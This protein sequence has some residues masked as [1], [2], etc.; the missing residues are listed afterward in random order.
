MEAPVLSYDGE[1]TINLENRADFTLPVVTATDNEDAEVEVTSVIT[2]ADGEELEA[3]DTTVAGTYTVTYSAVDAAGNASEKLV[4]TVVV[5][6]SPSALAVEEAVAAIDALPEV[7]NLTLEDSQDV[8]DARA[9]VTAAVELGA[10]EEDVTNLSKLVDAEA[11][12][13]TAAVKAV[14]N[15]STRASLLEALQNPV[16][17]LTGVNSDWIRD[18]QAEISKGVFIRTVAEIQ[19][20]VIDV[21]ANAKATQTLDEALADVEDAMNAEELLAALKAP[22]L[23]LT[24]IQDDLANVY[25]Y[26]YNHPGDDADVS[27]VEGLQEYVVDAAPAKLAKA[28][29]AIE[30]APTQAELLT[31]LKSDVLGLSED[32][33]DGSVKEYASLVFEMNL[34]TVADVQFVLDVTAAELSVEDTE[35]LVGSEE[36]EVFEV[37]TQEEI[38]DAEASLKET[39]KVVNN[40]RDG[41][42]KKDLL[43]RLDAV[44]EAIADAKVTLKV[45]NATDAV[46]ALLTIEDED[47]SGLV[48]DLLNDAETADFEDTL[49]AFELAYNGDGEDVKGAVDLVAALD[50]GT[51]KEVL[52]DRLEVIAEKAQLAKAQNAVFVADNASL[53]TN[54]DIV[55]AI[56]LFTK[57]ETAVNGYMDSVERDAL[58]DSLTTIKED[59]ELEAKGQVDE[60]LVV[61]KDGEDTGLVADLEAALADLEENY[62]D[63]NVAAFNTALEKASLAYAGDSDEEVLGAVDV[64]AELFSGSMKTTLDNRLMV[65]G[66]RIDMAE[67]TFAVL[68]VEKANAATPSEVVAALELFED[69]QEMVT[70]LPTSDEKSDLQDR[71]DTVKDSLDAMYAE[72]ITSVNDAEDATEI[73][74]ALKVALELEGDAEHTDLFFSVYGKTVFTSLD[75]IQAAYDDVVLT[76]DVN[77]ADVKTTDDALLALDHKAYINLGTANRVEVA[78]LFFTIHNVTAKEE[79]EFKSTEEVVAALD[80]AIAKYNSLLAGVNNAST[81]VEMESALQSMYNAYAPELKK[82]VT[83]DEAEDVLNTKNTEGFSGFKTFEQINTVLTPA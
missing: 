20:N 8:A 3:I 42:Y 13:T 32:V 61:V 21:V 62:S 77:S 5:A 17:G 1:T 39:L 72:F 36:G 82:D 45:Q 43:S 76:G 34:Q 28:I 81:I 53:T 41:S 38:N 51:A 73:G 15:A 14:Q 4:L 68:S 27:D 40:L 64:V 29:K 12:L 16:L 83:I 59:I 60:V 11:K 46:D 26:L 44:E 58:L 22:V 18:Y 55:K 75:E 10:M 30:T 57:A 49:S 66:D 9:L 74:T 52:E 69:A 80:S 24:G 33:V 56:E 70:A 71:L 19:T 47:S 79:T 78:E 7:S 23:G 35:A 67:A 2:N 65:A 31:A 25:E 48:V 50:A 63:V 37:V 6:K 54:A